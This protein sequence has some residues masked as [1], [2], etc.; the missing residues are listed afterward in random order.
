[1]I[2]LP[3]IKQIS[4]WTLGIAFILVSPD[5]PA[6]DTT[7]FSKNW[8]ITSASD[9]HFYRV[10]EEKGGL[11][12]YRT[13]TSADHA[14]QRIAYFRTN[15][16]PKGKLDPVGPTGTWTLWHYNGQKE[17]EKDYS[18]KPKRVINGWSLKGVQTVKDGNGF[19]KTY[20]AQGRIRWEEEYKDGLAEGKSVGYFSN[21]DIPKVKYRA[22]VKNGKYHG[23]Y[24]EYYIDGILRKTG[25]F[26]NGDRIGQWNWYKPSGK[27]LDSHTYTLTDQEK[28]REK[29]TMVYPTPLNIGKVKEDIGYPPLMKEAEVEGTVYVMVLVDEK[30][31]VIDK[32]VKSSRHPILTKA[33]L[34]EVP[35]LRFKPATL[36]TE[37]V[38]LWVTIPFEFKLLFGEEE[39]VD[40]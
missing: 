14:P 20:D 22:D 4:L 9:Q 24:E 28:Y 39:E 19:L 1:M 34:K 35:N 3:M 5:L 12:E 27:K 2:S 16:I 11:Y 23:K 7:Y 37:E 18:S 40:R 32:E 6:Q 8:K 30:G 38:A 21:N 29:D 33:V 17:S 15:E 31:K 10:S 13:Y 26:E 25:R 36:A